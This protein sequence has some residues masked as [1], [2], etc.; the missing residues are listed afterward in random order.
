MSIDWIKFEP[1]W[2]EPDRSGP[3]LAALASK[4][5]GARNH[6]AQV[7]S[8]TDI[9]DVADEFS[10]DLREPYYEKEV[11]KRARRHG[12]VTH[13]TLDT[14]KRNS[15]VTEGGFTGRVVR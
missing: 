5:V 2:I 11:I 1:N 3:R 7:D 13:G 14:H 15:P 9:D 6:S 4:L 12:S 10:E 8:E